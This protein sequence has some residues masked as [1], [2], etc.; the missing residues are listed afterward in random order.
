[1]HTDR[2]IVCKG[3]HSYG[4]SMK[5]YGPN[6]LT[7]KSI[8]LQTTPPVINC[9]SLLHGIL[10][11]ST[12]CLCLRSQHLLRRHNHSKNCV[13]GSISLSLMFQLSDAI[14]IIIIISY[15]PVTISD[16]IWLNIFNWIWLPVFDWIWLSFSIWCNSN[17]TQLFFIWVVSFE[18]Q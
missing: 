5:P 13:A 18:L 15:V 9:T 7:C 17:L 14:A 11:R 6:T 12:L 8:R 2:V 16:L 10:P 1:M 3:R 4:L